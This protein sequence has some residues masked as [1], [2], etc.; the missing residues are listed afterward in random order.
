MQEYVAAISVV[1]VKLPR[2][3]QVWV[4][5]AKRT[6]LVSTVPAVPEDVVISSD[7]TLGGTVFDQ[8]A[9]VAGGR[10]ETGFGIFGDIAE[11]MARHFGYEVVYEDPYADGSLEVAGESRAE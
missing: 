10:L 8:Q 9:Q 1:G 6:V 3:V 7:G 2:V 5:H 4:L 11:T